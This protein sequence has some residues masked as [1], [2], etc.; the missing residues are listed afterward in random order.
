MYY[1]GCDSLFKRLISVIFLSFQSFP[2]LESEVKEW[3]KKYKAFSALENQ[4]EK[5]KNLK[6]EMA[7]SLVIEKESVSLIFFF[8]F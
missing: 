8:S 5:I 3:E 7:W 1:L 6:S 4:K 2:A